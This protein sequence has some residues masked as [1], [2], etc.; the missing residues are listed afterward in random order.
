MSEAK[1]NHFYSIN[2][3]KLVNLR[4]YKGLE[5]DADRLCTYSEWIQ[6]HLT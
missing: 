2:R 6:H 4:H 3:I 5:P 1:I